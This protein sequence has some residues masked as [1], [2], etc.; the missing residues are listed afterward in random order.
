MAVLLSKSSHQCSARKRPSAR[1]A[2]ETDSM[3][4]L[5]ALDELVNPARFLVPFILRHLLLAKRE[6]LAVDSR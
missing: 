5:P 6:H 2:D 1:I 4:P 3:P